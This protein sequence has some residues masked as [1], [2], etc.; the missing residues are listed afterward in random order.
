M[1]INK[2]RCLKKCIMYK[3]E[4]TYLQMIVEVV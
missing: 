1:K 2:K 3:S 4:K